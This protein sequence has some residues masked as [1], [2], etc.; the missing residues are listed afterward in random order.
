MTEEQYLQLLTAKNIYACSAKGSYQKLERIWHYTQLLSRYR[1]FI[2][3][4]QRE[5]FDRAINKILE[6]RE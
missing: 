6:L 2:Q 1:A 3:T 5:S 4:D